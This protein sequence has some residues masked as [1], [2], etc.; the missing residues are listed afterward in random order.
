MKN[1]VLLFFLLAYSALNSQSLQRSSINSMG[2]S[3]QKGSF[4]LSQS[5][6]QS[7]LTAVFVNENFI[8]QGFQQKSINTTSQK[9]F[10]LLLYPNPNNGEFAFEISGNPE[11]L[12]FLVYDAQGRQ[13]ITESK[14]KNKLTSVTS[15]D[16]APGMYVLFLNGKSG[17]LKQQKFTVY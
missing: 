16:L 6:G 15:V 2:K 10:D 4:I 3:S 8:R 13:V 9:S 14:V 5:V 12:S 1:V 17:L 11:G 7:S